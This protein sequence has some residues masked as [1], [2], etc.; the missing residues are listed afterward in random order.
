MCRESDDPVPYSSSLGVLIGEAR[1]CFSV[2]RGTT[3]LSHVW[4]RKTLVFFFGD[5][6][7]GDDAS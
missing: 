4:E 2:G 6:E 1:S 7:G 3:R 5:S